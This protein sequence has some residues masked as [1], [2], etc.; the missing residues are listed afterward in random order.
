M[1]TEQRIGVLYIEAAPREK[2]SHFLSFAKLDEV[3][4]R[5]PYELF[6]VYEQ[7]PHWSGAKGICYFNPVYVC[8]KLLEKDVTPNNYPFRNTLS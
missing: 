8:K 2:D 4:A 3:L 5:Y 1:L 7:Q 6:G